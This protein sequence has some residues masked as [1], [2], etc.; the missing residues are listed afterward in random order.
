MYV[1]NRDGKAILKKAHKFIDG[2]EVRRLGKT[3]GA[4]LVNFN[5]LFLNCFSC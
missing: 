3:M 1:E 5:L 4:L 2:L